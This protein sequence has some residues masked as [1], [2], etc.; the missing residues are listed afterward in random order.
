M[1]LEFQ[2][3]NNISPDLYLEP[4][5][6]NFQKKSTHEQIALITPK[7]LHLE[8]LPMTWIWVNIY[9]CL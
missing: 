6:E 2:K 5:L 9:I 3:Y 8:P 1:Q 7:T 4:I